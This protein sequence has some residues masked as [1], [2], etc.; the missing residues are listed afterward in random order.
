MRFIS[1]LLA[2]L[3]EWMSSID[4]LEWLFLIIA[5][6]EWD[7]PSVFL[8]TLLRS[9][10]CFPWG[11]FNMDSFF[12]GLHHDL[13]CILLSLLFSC[14]LSLFKCRSY[15]WVYSGSRFLLCLFLLILIIAGGVLIPV[16][17]WCDAGNPSP[18]T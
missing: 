16:I 12:M 9:A 15:L 4:A 3:G 17:A 1:F 5:P 18:P 14:A 7:C 13:R 6:T 11:G 2:K 8:K 10:S